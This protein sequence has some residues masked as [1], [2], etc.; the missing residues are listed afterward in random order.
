MI[1]LETG[2]D[3]PYNFVNFVIPFNFISN[4]HYPQKFHRRLKS[5]LGLIPQNARIA[6]AETVFYIENGIEFDFCVNQTVD[7]SVRVIGDTSPAMDSGEVGIC[8]AETSNF[9]AIGFVPDLP[10]K[11]AVDLTCFIE[12]GNDRINCKDIPMPE[13]EED[14]IKEVVYATIVTNVGDE[15]KAILS[16]DRTRD[17][18]TANLLGLLNRRDLSPGDFA[19]AREEG[20]VLDF[21]VQR[22]VTTSEYKQLI[23][24]T[25]SMKT[26]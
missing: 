24:K 18:E 6:P 16:L 9:F 10:C 17:G 2:K 8:S 15:R 26:N 14:C 4:Y 7:T 11:V 13:D 5:L 12:D 19:V 25:L 3:N 20:Q 1:L 22:L 23:M 21:C